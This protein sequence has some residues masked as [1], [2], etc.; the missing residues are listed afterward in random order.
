MSQQI[1]E[2]VFPV[3]PGHNVVTGNVSFALATLGPTASIVVEVTQVDGSITKAKV[4]GCRKRTTKD[5]E[6]TLFLT[7]QEEQRQDGTVDLDDLR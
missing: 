6:R 2:D 3:P 1:V 5:G 7:I 4:T